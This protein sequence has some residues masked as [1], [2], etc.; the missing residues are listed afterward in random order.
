[1]PIFHKICYFVSIFILKNQY[2]V[3]NFPYIIA[4]MFPSWPIFRHYIFNSSVPVS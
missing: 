1:M 2:F 4:T 3:T